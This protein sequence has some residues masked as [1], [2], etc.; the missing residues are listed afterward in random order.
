[1]NIKQLLKTTSILALSLV[2]TALSVSCS[3]AKQPQDGADIT[4]NLTNDINTTMKKITEPDITSE[5]A[6][7]EESFDT[8]AQDKNDITTLQTTVPE[9]IPENVN[10]PILMYHTSSENSPGGLAELF[11]K[12]S[13][14]ELQVKTLAENGYTF[15]TFDD[16]EGINKIK[17]PIL[18]TFD[19]GYL[20]NYTEIFPILKKYNAKIT[21]FLII[22]SVNPSNLTEEMI[23][24]MSDSGLVKFESHTMSH[25]SLVAVSSSPS[26]LDKEIQDS[27]NKIEAITGKPVTA[28]SYPNGEFNEAVKTCT[29][30]YYKYGVRKDLGM[31]NTSYDN[32]EVRRFRVNRSTSIENYMSMLSAS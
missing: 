14:F 9:P 3:T 13:E 15:C 6:E 27:K 17:K 23:K 16:M 12:P 1:M 22:S 29:S 28:L 4:G 19:D 18:L 7:P 24:E 26:L 25:P 10:V 20:E 5:Y 2:I 11:V 30:K 21:I 31:H 8:S 32:F